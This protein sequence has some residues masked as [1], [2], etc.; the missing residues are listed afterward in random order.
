VG[1]VTAAG[2]VSIHRAGT[3]RYLHRLIY[4]IWHGLALDQLPPVVQHRCDDRRCVNPLHLE[5]GTL[6]TNNADMRAKGRHA[7]G[8]T[9]GQARLTEADVRAIRVSYT[10]TLGEV[11]T[12]ARCYGVSRTTVEDVVHGRT[13]AWLVAS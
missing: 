4:A 1:G 9:H 8:E 7:R 12:L 3:Q 11:A 10:G 5:G 13:W 2:Y 6:V